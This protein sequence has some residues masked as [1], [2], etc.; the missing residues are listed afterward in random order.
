MKA[1]LLDAQK[2]GAQY[3]PVRLVEKLRAAI[4]QTDSV[5][6]KGNTFHD[7]KKAP[8]RELAQFFKDF[9]Q[10]M[11]EAKRVDSTINE[12]LP[13]LPDTEDTQVSMDHSE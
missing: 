8:K 2:A 10:A 11:D 3:I 1:T 4:A 12:L 7:K 6:E 13:D 5:L 9:K